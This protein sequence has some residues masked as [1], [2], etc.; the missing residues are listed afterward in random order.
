VVPIP[1]EAYPSPA[2]RPRNSRLSNEKLLRQFG[3]A[4]PSWEDSLKAVVEAS[5]R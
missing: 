2:R 1:S 4:L 5:P 3:F